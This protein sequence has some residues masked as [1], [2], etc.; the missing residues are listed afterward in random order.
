M[1]RQPPNSTLFPYPTLSRSRHLRDVPAVT[2]ETRHHI[3]AEGPLGGTIEGHPVVVVDPAKIGEL[4]MS[5]ERSSFAR[6]TRSEEHT[7]ELQSP[8][9]LVCRLLLAKKNNRAHRAARAKPHCAAAL[10]DRP[11]RSIATVGQSAP[12]S[13]AA[14]ADS[15]AAVPPP[16][17][18]DNRLAGR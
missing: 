18:Q 16:V 12:R 14:P 13:P 9:N 11:H 15:T 5:R 1:I 6:H 3:F 2:L 10:S 17:R 8:C 4:Q 7:S